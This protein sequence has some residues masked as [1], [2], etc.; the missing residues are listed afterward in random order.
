MLLM[1]VGGVKASMQA[2]V[3]LVGSLMISHW[4]V[5]DLA[6]VLL[7]LFWILVVWVEFGAPGWDADELALGCS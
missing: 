3:V 6:V 5:C 7:V 4:G 2:L 1:L